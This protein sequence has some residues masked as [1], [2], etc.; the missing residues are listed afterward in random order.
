MVK[1]EVKDDIKVIKQVVPKIS[2]G[3]NKTILGVTKQCQRYMQDVIAASIHRDGSTG[4]LAQNI[5]S[6]VGGWGISYWGGVGSVENLGK[7]AP[8][9]YVA[10]FGK[11]LDG[12]DFIPRPSTGSFNGNPPSSSLAG[13]GTEMWSSPGRYLMIPKNPVRPLNYIESTGNYFTANF[14]QIWDR[15]YSKVKISLGSKVTP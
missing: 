15:E 1:I 9:W 6:Q 10:N 12:Q 3:L 7:N 2:Q 8:Y 4:N 13:V 5:D 14:K 11:T